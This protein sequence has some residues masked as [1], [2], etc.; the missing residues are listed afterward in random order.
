MAIMEIV[1]VGH[2]VLRQEAKPVP[3]VTK[4]VQTLVK[5]MIDTMY[6]ADGV[7]LAA[8]Q[9]GVSQRIIVIDIGEGPTALVNPTIEEREGLDIDVEGCLSI[10]GVNGY[11]RRSTRV[12]VAYLDEKGKPQ[13]LHAE[14]VLSRALQHELDH[15]DGVLFIDNMLEEVKPQSEEAGCSE[16]TVEQQESR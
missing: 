13:R 12:V 6:H 7:G 11:V 3:K 2:D 14:G 9:I 16:Q 10:P 4:K 8:P 15:L 1:T 5:N